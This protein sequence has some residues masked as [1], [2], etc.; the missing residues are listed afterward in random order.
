MFTILCVF[1]RPGAKDL[2]QWASEHFQLGVFTAGAKEYADH[3]LRLLDP[4]DTLFPRRFRM[5]KQDCGKM[6]ESQMMTKDLLKFKVD[7]QR[8]ILVDNFVGS[9]YPQQLFVPKSRQSVRTFPNGILMTD[10]SPIHG[11]PDEFYYEETKQLMLVLSHVA[12]MPDVRPFLASHMLRL[13]RQA[14]ASRVLTHFVGSETK[15]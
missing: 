9:F 5:Y 13:Y 15:F 8:V 3:I 10:Y 11:L 2:I 12:D 4:S 6:P 14:F 7:L 1:S